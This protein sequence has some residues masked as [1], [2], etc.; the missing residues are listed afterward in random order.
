MILIRSFKTEKMRETETAKYK[1]K[2]RINSDNSFEKDLK[3]SVASLKG[4]LH[5]K[6]C[7]SAFKGLYRNTYNFR[8]VK[9]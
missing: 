3:I 1:P 5:L 9:Q 4:V 8:Q 2:I 7:S 6:V